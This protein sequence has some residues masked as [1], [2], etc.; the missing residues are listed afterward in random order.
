MQARAK[1]T[2]CSI[3]L[4][5]SALRSRYRKTIARDSQKSLSPH[6]NAG[7]MRLLQYLDL[8]KVTSESR[9][10]GTTHSVSGLFGGFTESEGGLQGRLKPNVVQ[11]S[12]VFSNSRGDSFGTRSVSTKGP[13]IRRLKRDKWLLLPVNF[14]AAINL[15]GPKRDALKASSP[16][17]VRLNL[18]NHSSKPIHFQ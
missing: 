14:E 18:R 1:R 7:R 5:M 2:N 11:R 4:S 3:R 10:R 9:T 13:N 17:P 16:R 6:V 12:I 8:V 15:R